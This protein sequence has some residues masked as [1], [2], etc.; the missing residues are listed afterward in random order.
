[1]RYGL[2][3]HVSFG[4]VKFG[5]RFVENWDGGI[6]AWSQANYTGGGAITGIHATQREQINLKVA[7]NGLYS[8]LYRK[9]FNN[10]NAAIAY[11]TV[12]KIAA[13]SPQVGLWQ[14]PLSATGYDVSLFGGHFYI[15]RFDGVG[16]AVNLAD[17][18]VPGTWVDGDLLLFLAKRI[19]STYYA[20][21]HNQRVGESIYASV[22]DTTY[23]Y[24]TTI[25]LLT[26]DGISGVTYGRIQAISL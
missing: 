6:A 9:I 13:F 18:L 10:R 4:P 20:S 11:K 3:P 17:K 19:N 8:I 25:I 12:L 5:T 21:V 24:N 26:Q 16:I 23:D 2:D 14:D 22:T 15:R 7:N 1:M